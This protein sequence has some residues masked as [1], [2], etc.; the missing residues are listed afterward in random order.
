MHEQL[1]FFYQSSHNLPI[2]TP[3]N[4]LFNPPTNQSIMQRHLDG[5][6]AD[7]EAYCES[8]AEGDAICNIFAVSSDQ[9]LL[10]F[11]RP[12]RQPIQRQWLPLIEK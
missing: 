8:A 10:V 1:L 2:G 12:Q 3:D 4:E 6:L 9:S 5:H 7:V 11:P